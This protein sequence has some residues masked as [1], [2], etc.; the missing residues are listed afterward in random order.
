MERAIDVEEVPVSSRD[1]LVCT[2]DSEMDRLRKIGEYWPSNA[3]LSAV[4]Q[5]K[6]AHGWVPRTTENIQDLEPLPEN[7]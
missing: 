6:R 3:P 5:R 4:E 7:R 2:G 1:E